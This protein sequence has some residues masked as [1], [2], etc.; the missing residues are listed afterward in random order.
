MTKEKVTTAYLEDSAKYW[1]SESEK[2]FKKVIIPRLEKRGLATKENIDALEHMYN[3]E[4]YH[5]YWHTEGRG[6][7]EFKKQLGK[8]FGGSLSQKDA[9][10]LINQVLEIG[11]N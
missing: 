2:A 9:D 5:T 3:E 1:Q 10:N 4:L 11:N 8:Y 7:L 6:L